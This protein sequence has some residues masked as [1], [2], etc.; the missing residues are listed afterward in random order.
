M[1]KSFPD[2]WQIDPLRRYSRSKS[3]VVKNVAQFWAFFGLHNFLRAGIVKIVLTLSPC[4][5]G[6]RQKD[7]REDTPT[8]PEVIE[9]NTLN[10]RP[11]F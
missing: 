2:F 9:S 1:I 7:S 3:K 11:D 6:C 5:A 8:N 10:F 4:L